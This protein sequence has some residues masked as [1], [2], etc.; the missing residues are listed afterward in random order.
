[1]INKHLG[2]SVEFSVVVKDQNG[3]A[4]TT[5]TPVVRV[6]DFTGA[7]KTSGTGT[8]A[9]SGSYTHTANTSTSWGTGPIKYDWCVTSALGT[10]I[11][12]ETNEVN[13]L[14]GTSE[15][16]SYVYEAE[17]SAYYSRIGDYLDDNSKDRIVASYNY[18]NR[19]LESLNITA[20]REKNADGLYDQSLRDMNAWLAIHAIVEDDQ[21][22]RVSDEEVPWYNK[23]KDNAM[24][25]YDDIAK[26]RIVFRDQTSISESGIEKPIR[27]AGSSVGTMV[28]NWDRTY[29]QGFRGSD[30]TR[31]WKLQITGTGTAGG[32]NECTYKWTN[33]EWIGTS[34]GVTNF[35]WVSLGDE[36][37]VRWTK[38]TSTGS[39]NIMAVG[40]EWQFTTNPI[41][42]QKGGINGAKSY[43]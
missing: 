33:D 7:L 36:V 20:P 1:M 37:Y 24:S 26:G 9:S 2:E 21:I 19:L 12:A 6:Y 23:F 4:L 32:V 39:T 40:D 27:S 5:E 10:G 14:F 18:I 13:M 30:F 11:I 43:R 29:G 38:G 25:K 22:N 31:T 3:T 15:P 41:A 42:S 8:H 16:A 28:T 34:T 17:L 35:E